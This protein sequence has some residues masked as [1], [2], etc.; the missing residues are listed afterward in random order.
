VSDFPLPSHGELPPEPGENYETLRT[1]FKTANVV[2]KLWQIRMPAK[3]TAPKLSQARADGLYAL[4][5]VW[6]GTLQVV[7]EGWDELRISDTEI[8]QLL[9]HAV[10]RTRLRRFRNATF[11][12]QETI[13][14]PQHRG[15]YVALYETAGWI[16]RVHLALEK[17][18]AVHL[19]RADV[20]QRNP[21]SAVKTNVAAWRGKVARASRALTEAME[22]PDRPAVERENAIELVRQ[23]L[24]DPPEEGR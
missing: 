8:D 18:F 9:D 3:G 23:L 20:T 14:G 5:G 22:D 1:Y 17:Y 13:R 7:L 19:T 11:H 21:Q 15:P 2:Y 16:Q 12:Y 10:N 6:L 24:M 4:F